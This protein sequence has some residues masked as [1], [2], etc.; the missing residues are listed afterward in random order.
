MFQIATKYVVICY[1]ATENE[2]RD[3]HGFLHINT[4][5]EEWN[6]DGG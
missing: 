2:Y 4:A 3:L 6:T 1:T 5:K